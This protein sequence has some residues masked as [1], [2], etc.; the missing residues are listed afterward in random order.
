A[1]ADTPAPSVV[2]WP[3][4]AKTPAALRAQAERLR[5][6]LAD[7]DGLS[8]ADIGHSLATTRTAF[9][10]RAV[11]LGKGADELLSGLDALAN[12]TEAAG[13]TRGRVADGGLAVLFSGQGS[14]RAA[15]GRELYAAYPVFAAALDE[16]C[17]CLDGRLAEPLRE[18]LSAEPPSPRAELLDR[19]SYT[20]PALFAIEVALYRLA[21]SWG[22][23]PGHL[24]GHSVGEI[25]A[26]HVAGV[27]TLPDACTLVAARGRLMQAI[28]AKG[29]MAALQ[30]DADEAAELLAGMEDRLDL[31]A[32]NGP[33]SVVISGDHEAVHATAATWRERGRKARLLKVSHA[34]HSPHMDTML[35]ELRAVASGLTFSAP[36]IPIVSNVTGRLATAAEL[37]TPDYW[38]RHARHA[39]R[40]M[41][42]VH[43]LLD[44]GV[45]TFLELGPDAPLTAMTR[46]CLAA[47][48]GPAPGRPRPAAVAALRRDRPE[49][50]TFAAAMAQAYVRGAEVAW[51]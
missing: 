38:A 32:V 7:H 45:T 47:R 34:F 31:A 43:T 9:A 15:M 16:V 10:H 33:S 17:D 44:A 27:L 24:M 4:S 12:G 19:T 48:P 49:V 5:D 28:T 23:T 1:P 30:A 13:V 21:E 51:D 50:R 35:D 22:L 8:P 2:A 46:E 36:A 3:I 26:A 25:A 14:Q 37:A 40:F 39:V 11:I 41:D 42:G 29:A 6:H 20:Q 18:V